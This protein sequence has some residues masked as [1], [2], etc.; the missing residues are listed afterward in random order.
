MI[1]RLRECQGPGCCATTTLAKVALAAG[2]IINRLAR[3]LL[4]ILYAYSEAMA[5][6]LMAQTMGHYQL[7]RLRGN[8]R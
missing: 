6:L 8:S 2:V 5:T 4:S 3:D 1:T 7:C